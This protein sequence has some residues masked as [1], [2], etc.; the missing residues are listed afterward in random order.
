M[1][2]PTSL[3]ADA[4]GRN[5]AETTAGSMA[6]KNRIQVSLRGAG[7]LKRFVLSGRRVPRP[8][9]TTTRRSTCM[10]ARTD[11]ESGGICQ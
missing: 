5:L 4:L 1:L 10:A 11:R 8:V 7:I 2:N 3:L 9:S 6:I